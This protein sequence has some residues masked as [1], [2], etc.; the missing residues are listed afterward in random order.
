MQN[1]KCKMQNAKCLREANRRS[2]EKTHRTDKAKCSFQA[3][4]QIGV[5]RSV[6]KP[7]V[8]AGAHDGPSQI[9]RNMLSNPC[10]FGASKA[11]PP[12]DRFFKPT[13]KPKFE[14]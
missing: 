4:F 1:A 7:M 12:T 14:G 2:C 8:G 9:D 3:I 6:E 5:C 11:P 10:F 13:N